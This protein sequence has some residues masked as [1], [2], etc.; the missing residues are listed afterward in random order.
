MNPFDYIAAAIGIDSAA[1]TD[2]DYCNLDYIH[3]FISSINSANYTNCYTLSY[4]IIS[5]ISF[6][7]VVSHISFGFATN[8]LISLSR[9]YLILQLSR[10]H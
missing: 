4:C 6:A 3:N 7:I 2:F 1:N 9:T 8:L 10:S 5:Y